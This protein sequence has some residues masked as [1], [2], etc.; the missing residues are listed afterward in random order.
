MRAAHLSLLLTNVQNGV[1]HWFLFS[2]SDAANIAVIHDA[3]FR[4]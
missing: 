2:M 3:S 4:P 1:G